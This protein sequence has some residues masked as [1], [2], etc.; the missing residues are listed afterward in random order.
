MRDG[1]L[2]EVRGLSKHFTLTRG[3]FR[4]FLGT[5]RAVDGVDFHV[6][7]GE[8]LAL[9][10]ESGCGKT[11]VGR[12][13]L[14]VV[15]PTAGSIH[16][17]FDEGEA[18]DIAAVTGRRQLKAMRREMAMIFQDPFS[19]LNPRLGVLDIVAEPFITHGTIKGRRNLEDRVAEL[20]RSVRLDPGLMRR[21]PHEFSGGQR[22][23][24]GIARAL[25]LRPKFVVADEPVSALDVS[26]QAQ[27][28]N[29]L[30][31]LRDE[32][33]LSYIFISHNLA[34]VKHISDRIA[35]MYM[36]RLVEL[37]ETEELFL[38]PRHPYTEALLAAVPSTDERHHGSHV[39]LR[40]TIGDPTNPPT[41][42]Y[43]HP[44]CPHAQPMCER[45]VPALADLGRPDAPR[46]AACHFARELELK[47]IT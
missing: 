30:E 7:R 3:L 43:F 16:L 32:F 2:L 27:I 34:V 40:G 11:T 14:R 47:G 38:A 15:D 24:I 12:C 36:G 44:R 39:E 29:L 19:S 10:G 25:A 26:V 42:C 46:Q 21:Y 45:K 6:T 23:R 33:D 5:V 22:Q 35:V 4:R 31:E 37:A 13:I 18:V 41:G 9:V 17:E 8:T 20:L 28:L 1:A